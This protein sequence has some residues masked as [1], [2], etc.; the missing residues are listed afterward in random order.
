MLRRYQNL[1]IHLADDQSTKDP[2]V[3]NYLLSH[4]EINQ[5]E[6]ILDEI[7]NMDSVTKFLQRNG[8]CKIQ[9]AKVNKL[10]VDKVSSTK[11]LQVTAATQDINAESDNT[12]D[13]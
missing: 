9:D 5:I 11:C 6:E 8:T 7:E 3:V 12:S 1:K 10:D 2:S 4:S 13:F